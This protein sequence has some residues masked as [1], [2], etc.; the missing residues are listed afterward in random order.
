M[1]K[2]VW[3]ASGVVED[4]DKRQSAFLEAV[5][6]KIR[7]YYRELHLTAPRFRYPLSLGRLAKL[8]NRSHSAVLHAVRILAHTIPEGSDGLPEVWYDRISSEK[9]ASHR[10]YRIFL[11]EKRGIEYL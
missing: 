6:A 1:I 10:P 2:R 9:N 3:I 8:L 5:L 11:R 4:L 7:H